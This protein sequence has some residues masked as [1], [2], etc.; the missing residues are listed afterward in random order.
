MT[1]K[2][3][4]LA[5]LVAFVAIAFA[6][7]ITDDSQTENKTYTETAALIQTNTSNTI[8]TTAVEIQEI[9]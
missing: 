5:Y 6:Y 8:S 3:K 9:K 4:S 1:H 2:I 7:H